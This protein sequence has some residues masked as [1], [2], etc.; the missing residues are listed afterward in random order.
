MNQARPWPSLRGCGLAPGAWNVSAPVAAR[1]LRRPTAPREL[2]TQPKPIEAARGACALRAVYRGLDT[3]RPASGRRAAAQRPAG[4]AR[5]NRTFRLSRRPRT[6]GRAAGA[7]APCARFAAPGF[8]AAFAV[9]LRRTVR[10]SRRH[11][12]LAPSFAGWNARAYYVLAASLGRVN[13]QSSV[14]ELPRPV[15]AA[16]KPANSSARRP[17]APRPTPGRVPRPPRYRAAR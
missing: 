1:P 11:P 4:G 8:V 9:A 7:A 5:R 17:F 13:S 15:S 10:R 6:K 3:L 14:G 2:L 12:P 16:G